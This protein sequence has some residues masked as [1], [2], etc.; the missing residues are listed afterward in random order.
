[1][2]Q[3]N[4][5]DVIRTSSDC[6][7]EIMVSIQS[8]IMIAT[9]IVPGE[10]FPA[11]HSVHIALLSPTQSSND[12]ATFDVPQ[13]T[14]FPDDVFFCN[15]LPQEVAARCWRTEEALQALYQHTNRTTA[16]LIHS[17]IGIGEQGL[18]CKCHTPLYIWE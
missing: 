2:S 12:H 5:F 1:M 15:R 14:K 18:T 16:R 6:F 10:H 9:I 13:T 7:C 3:W 4:N 8:Q 17:S 11:L